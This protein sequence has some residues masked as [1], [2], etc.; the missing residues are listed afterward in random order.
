[1]ADC[2]QVMGGPCPSRGNVGEWRRLPRKAEAELRFQFPVP[3]DPEIPVR[4]R[5]LHQQGH[6]AVVGEDQHPVLIGADGDPHR[7]QAK[8]RVHAIRLFRV[9]PRQT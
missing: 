2:G 5:E 7:L 9:E 4:V 8:L 6:E 3:G 1:M